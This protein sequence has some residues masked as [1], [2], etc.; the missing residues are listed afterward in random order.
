MVTVLV[1]NM[2]RSGTYINQLTGELAY[3]AF[4]PNRLPF[5]LKKDPE[6]DVLL[7]EANLSLGRLDGVSEIVPDIDFL[8]LIFGRKEATFS[9]QVEG[10]QATFAD[11]LKAEAKLEDKDIPA[12]VREIF[13]YIS[14]MNYGI[15][16]LKKIPLSLRLMQGIHEKLLKGVRGQE[17]QPGQFRKTQNWVGGPT[18]QT[19]TYVPVPPHDLLSSLGN[20]EN[21]LREEISIP[22][23]IK[24]ALIH[25]QFENIHPFLDGNGRIGRLL[26]T[27]YL[28]HQKVLKHPILYLSVYFKK[29]QK[30]YYYWLNNFHEKDDIEGWIKFF[31][32]GVITTAKEGFKTAQKILDLK[33]KDTQKITTEITRVSKNALVLLKNLYKNPFV[34]LKSVV[35]FTGLSKSNAHYLLK[36]VEKAGILEALP[37]KPHRT[38]NYIYKEYM[39]LLNA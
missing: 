11:V 22:Q 13:N 4:I 29:N 27:F 35:L 12:D 23:L 9:S 6:I 30:D 20:L 28:W 33:E 10:T 1:I 7:S 8:T 24:T 19:A 21:F 5:D 39:D 18:I 37:S 15:E 26:I 3:K 31:L 25:A 16:E 2:M 36:K 34:S 32:K 38:K 14:A 17:R